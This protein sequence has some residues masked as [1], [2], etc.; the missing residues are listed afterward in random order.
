ML[1][2]T[3][4]LILATSLLIAPK[5]YAFDLMNVL[6]DTVKEQLQTQSSSSSSLSN[7][8]N[9]QIVSGLREALKVGTERVVSQIGAADGY[10]L[11]KQIHIP[12]PAQLQQVQGVLNKFGLSA[13]ADDV[14]LRLNR[15]AELAAPKAKDLIWKAIESMSLDEAQAIYNGPKDA[16]TQYFKKVSTA[17]LTKTIAPIAENSLNEVGAIQ[18]YDSL[19][20]S[21][22]A[23]PFVPDVK[24]NLI[25]HTTKLAI[26]GIF[27]Y[28]AV[29]EAAIRENPAKR[30]TE[31]LKTVFGK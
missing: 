27:H 6:K 31:I 28:L 3:S 23:L 15:A 4:A 12:L 11:D 21:Y 26:D 30:T 14:E 13:M 18:A 9:S 5:S 7:I 17:D 20:G 2:L 24:A 10:N 22:K 29:E 1:R 19:M 25:D 16:A 8:S